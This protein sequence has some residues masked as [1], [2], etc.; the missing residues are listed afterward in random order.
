MDLMNKIGG[1]MRGSAYGGGPKLGTRAP[2]RLSVNR[3]VADG[4][5]PRENSSRF[6]RPEPYRS[7]EEFRGEDRQSANRL[8]KT[9]DPATDH[10]QPFF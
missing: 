10:S 2:N 1:R 9:E 5:A 3:Q 8:S 7:V 4:R 6:E